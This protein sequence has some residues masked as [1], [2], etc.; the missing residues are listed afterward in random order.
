MIRSVTSRI[1]GI[2][3]GAVLGLLISIPVDAGVSPDDYKVPVSTAQQLRIEGNYAYAGSG[4]DAQTS[5]GKA[6]VTYRRFYNSLPYAWDIDITAIGATSRKEGDDQDG[7][8]STLV[9]PSVRKYF[10]PKG[11]F[12]YSADAGFTANDDFDR[13]VIDATPGVGYGRFIT[14]TP[15]AQAVRIDEFLL[16]EGVIKKNLPKKTL[17]AVAQIIERRDEFEEEHGSATYKVQWFEAMEKQIAKTGLFTAKGFG[18]VGTLRVDEVLFQERINERFTGWDVS[19]GVRFELLTS[20]KSVDRQKPGLSLRARYSRPVSWKSQFDVSARYTS[21]F[22]DFGSDIFTLSSTVSYLYELSNRI[23]YTLSN[24][25]TA[26]RSNP[27][28]KA[29]VVQTVSSG[30]LFYLEN[31]INLTVTGTFEKERNRKSSQTFNTGIL[32]RFR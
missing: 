28:V 27:N 5:D 7:S 9:T 18:A 25:L 24:L 31:Q 16:E 8:Y 10:N 11:N 1:V 17:I 6:A 29:R 19:S 4:S 21:P 13:P 14:V 26:S 2:T 20:D 22:T 3:I 15:L 23:D 12:F 30:F 32:Y